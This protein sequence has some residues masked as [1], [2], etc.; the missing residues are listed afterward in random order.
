MLKW[1][2]PK[3]LE[4]Y[5]H[6]PG[7]EALIDSLK[8][9]SITHCYA[10][11]WLA[12]RVTFET[13]ENIICSLPFN[14][15]FPLWPIPYKQQVDEQTD[16]AYVLT[17]HF[18]PRLSAKSFEHHLAA[19]GITAEKTRIKPF[20]IYRDFN[21]P[22]YVSSREYILG[23]EHFSIQTNAGN[24]TALLNLKDKD[25]ST[26]WISSKTQSKGQWVALTFDSIKTVNGVTVFHLPGKTNKPESFKITGY[27]TVDGTASWHHLAGPVEAKPERLRFVNNHP[28]YTGLSQ[29]IRFAPQE[30]EA[31]R[32][33][34][35]DP[36][37]KSRWGLAE[38]EVSAFLDLSY[39][40]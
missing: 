33:E 36:D 37:K 34:I 23:R 8:Q 40:Y 26:T 4:N 16:P 18:R 39:E 17:N 20:L 6:T 7:I 31:I 12:Y 21:F 9:R 24:A 13:D 3:Q 28:V 2:N 35:V 38:I 5:S 15:R 19:S 30:V 14:E 1:N 32:I 29:Q 11:F 27:K 10:S 25:F 22:D